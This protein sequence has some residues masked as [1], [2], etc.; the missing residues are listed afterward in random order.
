MWTRSPDGRLYRSFSS[1]LIWVRSQYR[2]PYGRLHRNDVRDVNLDSSAT[3]YEDDD[4]ANC[5]VFVIMELDNA[6]DKD[7]SIFFL[8]KVDDLIK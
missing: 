7:G 8:D 6:T 5:P 4:G 2:T 1:P 3:S